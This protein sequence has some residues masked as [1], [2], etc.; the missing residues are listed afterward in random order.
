MRLVVR[1]ATIAAVLLLP[2]VAHAADDV[3]ASYLLHCRG[4]HLA[5]G[6]G[7]P[8]VIP[9]LID[10]IGRIV[11]S[12]EGREYVVRVPGVSQSSLDDKK[13]AVLLNWVL[14]SFN[15]DTLPGDFRPYSAADVTAARKKVLADPLKYRRTLPR[16][17]EGATD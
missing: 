15:A 12:P 8:T 7:V 2:G 9:T 16:H 14:E 3:R 13:L 17:D 4:C 5:D 10:E 11:A 1:L 6:A